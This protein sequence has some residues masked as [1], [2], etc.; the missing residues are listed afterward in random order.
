MR[1][2]VVPRAGKKNE[3]PRIHADVDGAAPGLFRHSPVQIMQP[4][5][6][7]MLEAGF[8][9]TDSIERSPRAIAPAGG[10]W[11]ARADIVI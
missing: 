4:S 6:M 8:S 2:V 10:F 5:T 9:V 11:I 7:R 1:R 3:P